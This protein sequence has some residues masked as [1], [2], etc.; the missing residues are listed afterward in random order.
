[1]LDIKF[2]FVKSTY[3]VQYIKQARFTILVSALDVVTFLCH[4]NDAFFQLLFE[5]WNEDRVV[6]A[7]QNKFTSKIHPVIACYA[8]F[9]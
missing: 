9:D 7:Q 6:Q 8:Q 3:G 2:R 5:I 1:M 4:L